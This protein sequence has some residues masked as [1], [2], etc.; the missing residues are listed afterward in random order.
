MWKWAAAIFCVLGIVLSLRAWNLGVDSEVVPAVEGVP[1]D[2]DAVLERFR[3]GLRIPTVSRQ[4]GLGM[5]EAAFENFRAYLAVH[6]PGIHEHLDLEIVS[7]HSLL[8]RWLGSEPSLPGTVLLAHQDVV[9]VDK[10]SEADWLHPP[11]AADVADGFVWGR[12]SLDDKFGLF[13]ILEATEMLLAEGFEPRRT[14]YLSLGHDEEVGG[15]QG[16]VQIAKLFGDR[17]WPVGL[18]L[19]EGGAIVRGLVPGVD[20]PVAIVGV[21]EKGFVS[22]VLEVDGMGGHSSAP[23]DQSAIGIISAAIVKLEEQR[24]PMRFEGAS[25]AFFEQGVGPASP[26]GMR[27]L[28]GN[29]WLFEPLLL[30]FLDSSPMMA[31]MTRTTTAPTIFHAGLKENVLPARA[32]ATVNFRLLPGDS[33][34]SVLA[35][36]RRIVS[37]D[38]IDIS[39]LE[40]AREASPSSRTDS[41][42]WRALSRTVHEVFPGSVIAPYLLLGGTDSRYFRDLCDC[43]YRFLPI[44]LE[45]DGLRRAH[46]SNERIPVAGIADGVRFYRRL[47]ENAD[48]AR[49]GSETAG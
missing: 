9:P 3:G 12:G 27:I 40:P 30:A 23:P 22:F 33:G 8:F 19:D 7:G 44:E 1:V 21:A 16:A 34:D 10:G 6:Y 41:E 35:E 38:R 31:A 13:A 32:Q 42:A 29:L 2:S 46:G 25:R 18:V 17:R 47:I 48:A 4:P 26:F 36:V 37:D 5:D 28:Y 14:L 15:G 20:A 11:Y 39:M 24:F 43:V 45:S 49:L